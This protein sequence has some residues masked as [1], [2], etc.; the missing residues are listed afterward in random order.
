MNYLEYKGYKGTVEHSSEDDCFFGKVVGLGKD[1]IAYEGK[2]MA[3]LRADF[4]AGIDSY[5]QGFRLDSPESCKLFS[6]K[7]EQ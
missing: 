1:L 6:K 2:T 4:E 3:E 7:N 5:L